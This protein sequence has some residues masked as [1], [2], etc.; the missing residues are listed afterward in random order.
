MAAVATGPALSPPPFRP[1]ATTPVPGVAPA[2]TPPPLRAAQPAALPPPASAPPDPAPTAE[3]TLAARPAAEQAPIASPFSPATSAPAVRPGSTPP[4][5][6]LDDPRL[7]RRVALALA[8]A[9]LVIGF[10]LGRR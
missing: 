1:P 7:H 8:L 2:H 10:L 9:G 3:Q 5:G 4:P 6:L